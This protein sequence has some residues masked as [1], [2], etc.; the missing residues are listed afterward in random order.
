MSSVGNPARALLANTRPSGY[1]VARVVSPAILE[2]GPVTLRDAAMKD[3]IK[4]IPVVGPLGMRLYWRLFGEKQ[5]PILFTGSVAEYWEE[6]YA[7]GRDSGV[8]SY[9]KFALFKAEVLNQFVA[10]HHIQSVVEFGCGDGHQLTLATYPRYLGL[11]LSASA[12]A[13]CREL[14]ADDETKT[15]HVMEEYA[16][17]VA[18]LS[19]SLDVVYHLVEDEVFERYMTTLFGAATRFVAIYSSDTNDNRGYE[20]THVR[21]RAFTS[22]VAERLPNWRLH[23]KIPNR[24]PYT[25]DYR[26]GSFADFVFYERA[27]AVG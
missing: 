14:F 9:G 1:L 20:G 25:G 10:K 4:R 5:Q 15:F 22:W 11:D 18:E 27:E 21:H 19:L 2:V 3:I 17:Q 6:R 7:A 12:V 26:E 8:G 23:S 16:E 13:R 24:Y